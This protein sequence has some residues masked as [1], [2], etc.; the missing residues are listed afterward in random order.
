MRSA[1]QSAVPSLR[2]AAGMHS[3]LAPASQASFGLCIID[4]WGE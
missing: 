1:E 3:V 4:D 2:A